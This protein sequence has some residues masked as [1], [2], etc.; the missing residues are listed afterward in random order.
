MMFG[1]LVHE[2]DHGV[3]HGKAKNLART[4]CEEYDKVLESC[5]VLVLPTI[6]KKTPKVPQKNEIHF[7]KS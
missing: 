7:G 4:L 1:A 2:G 5:N 6:V 3:F